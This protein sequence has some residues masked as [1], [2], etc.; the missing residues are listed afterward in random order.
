[1]IELALF[2]TRGVSLKRWHDVG[3]FDREL[4]LY[5]RLQTH[6][7][8]VS[9]VSY[10]G[11]EDLEYA[12]QLAGFTILP[13]RS[14]LPTYAYALLAPKIHRDALSK[15]MLI[16]T[17][18]LRG[19]ETAY[20]AHK[21]LNK[22][23]IVRSGY[24]WSQRDKSLAHIGTKRTIKQAEITERFLYRRCQAAVV[25]TPFLRDYIEQSYDLCPEKTFVVPNYVDTELFRPK[26]K[27]PQNRPTKQTQLIFIGRLVEQKNLHM[28]IKAVAPLDVQLNIIGDGPLR[29]ELEKLSQDIQANVH[30]SGKILNERLPE[31]LHEADI[32]VSTSKWEGHPKAL[33]EAMSCGLPAIVSKVPGNIDVIAH[34]VNGLQCELSAESFTAA[35]QLLVADEPRRQK[36]GQSAYHF[37]TE[38]YSL[39]S[40]TQKELALYHSLL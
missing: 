18:Q 34:G 12:D 17:N 11:E 20:L 10:G 3:I 5:R 25:P 13:N 38:N 30:F 21:L 29:G 28:L 35:I 32:F 6:G 15:A 19:A 7:V 40:V 24:V 22:P 14:N 39:A 36:M 31:Q 9:I 1:M 2:L 37:A 8:R 26:A 4:R 33:I 27:Q 16:K 23:L